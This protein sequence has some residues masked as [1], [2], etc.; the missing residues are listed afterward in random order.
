MAHIFFDFDST[1]VSI[2]TLDVLIS[3]RLKSDAEK[4]EIEEI[5]QQGMAGEMP[6]IE[7]LS[8][9]LS[10]VKINQTDIDLFSKS[11][12]KHLTHGIQ[13]T[14]Q[15]LQTS[16]HIVHI[17]SG[18]FKD[19]MLPTANVLNIEHQNIH[20]NTLKFDNNGFVIGLNH[21]NPLCQNGGKAK[22]IQALNVSEPIIM[23]GDG[24]TDLEVY[25]EMACSYFIGFGIHTQ[26][27]II[28]KESPY[29]A[30]NIKELN[31]ILTELIKR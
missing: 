11:L 7:S 22:I 6:L 19:Y 25:K 26:R 13:K 15:M 28:K 3:S 18:G 23:V 9:R 27:D 4:K 24:Y 17:L 2:E 29:F 20:A 14:I 21:E 31:T 5:T 1:L 10:V 16:G 12:P 30:K 8:Q